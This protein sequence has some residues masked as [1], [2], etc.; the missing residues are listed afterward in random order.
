[1]RPPPL[2]PFAHLLLLPIQLSPYLRL[3]AG[4]RRHLH[5]RAPQPLV[6]AG[7]RRHHRRALAL[8]QLQRALLLGA[9]QL[10]AQGALLTHLREE[11][12]RFGVQG[13]GGRDSGRV[14]YHGNARAVKH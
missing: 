7:G 8:Q 2:R 4:H 3:L 13:G 1:M 12:E 5:L 6:R 9:E 11:G 14:W 10:R